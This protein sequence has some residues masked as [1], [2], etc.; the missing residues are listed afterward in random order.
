MIRYLVIILVFIGVLSSAIYGIYHTGY[1]AG[2]NKA[3]DQWQKVRVQETAKAA[4]RIKQIEEANRKIE[5]DR[6]IV[7]ESLSYQLERAKQDVI[8]K[9][10]ALNA[11]YAEIDRLRFGASTVPAVGSD[12]SSVTAHT[13]ECDGKTVTIL[14]RELFEAL[15][16][17]F[18]RA[19]QVTEQ[20][21]ACQ[22]IL[23]E[24]RHEESP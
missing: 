15:Y 14:S 17:D 1:N 13:S 2:Y 23:L 7:Y 21:S 16:N 9:Q 11:T 8:D 19:D 12:A 20:L 3:D 24:D 22:A 6:Q 10:N 18:A 5:H 4:E